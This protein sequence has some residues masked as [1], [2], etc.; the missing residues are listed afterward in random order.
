MAVQEPDP[1][2]AVTH[3]RAGWEEKFKKY[4]NQDS[5]T[6]WTAEKRDKV[7]DFLLTT[8]E[9]L[10]KLEYQTKHHYQRYRTQYIAYNI[11]P[12]HEEANWHVFK[13][14]GPKKNKKTE[15]VSASAYIVIRCRIAIR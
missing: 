1:R 13:R 5:H 8:G 12:Q 6:V 9:D 2:S 10:A 14:L 15:K 4:L 7:V 3:D 11:A